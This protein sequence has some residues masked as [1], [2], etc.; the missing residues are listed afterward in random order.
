MINAIGFAV[1]S[2]YLL[3][4]IGTATKNNDHSVFSMVGNLFKYGITK[5]DHSLQNYIEEKDEE[6]LEKMRAV[7]KT[8]VRGEVK[9]IQKIEKEKYEIDM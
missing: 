5:I 4:V 9:P 3:A 7:K 6:M 2:T 8:G 1:V